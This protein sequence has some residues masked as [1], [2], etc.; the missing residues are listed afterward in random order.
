M[1]AAAVANESGGP[2][3]E[4]MARYLGPVILDAFAD[5]DVTEIYLNPGD[6]AVRFDTRSRG[7]VESGAH[8]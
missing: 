1:R 4:M 7:R 2:Y 5:D 6:G 8:L 3:G